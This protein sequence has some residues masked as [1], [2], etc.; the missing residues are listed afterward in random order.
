MKYLYK[1]PQKAY[2]YGNL[3]DTNKQR[4]R[5]DMEYELLDTGVFDEDRY[6]DVFVEFAK[7]TPDD[8]LIQITACNRGPEAATL[9]V[10]PT[11]LFRNTWSWGGTR[12]KPAMQAIASR[13][14]SSALSARRMIWSA[15]AIC[16]ARAMLRCCS[17]KTRRTTSASSASRTP[18]RM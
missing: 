6:W 16:I 8:V 7:E 15:S 11:L 4:G 17:P 3:V 14:G 18:V 5:T 1:Y 13:R 12:D 9:H 10:L 2:P